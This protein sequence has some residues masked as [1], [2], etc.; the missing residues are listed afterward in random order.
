[1]AKRGGQ[2]GNKNSA[3]GRDFE[4]TVKRALLAEDGKRLRAAAEK[5]LDLAAQGERWAVEFL[6]DTLDGKPAQAV[7][8]SVTRSIIDLDDADIAG[9]LAES[10]GSGVAG[11]PDVPALTAELH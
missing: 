6:R 4:Q 9:I 5:M 7:D 8:L 3:K 11:T 1:M 2:P 10:S